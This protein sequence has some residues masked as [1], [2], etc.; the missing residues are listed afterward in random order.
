[1]EK[2][3]CHHR[4]GRGGHAPQPFSNFIVSTVLTT[5]PS[6]AL[7]PHFQIRGAALA[8]EEHITSYT[9]PI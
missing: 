3:W 8:L 6:N 5:A 9:N 7:T 4:S 1:M 2:E